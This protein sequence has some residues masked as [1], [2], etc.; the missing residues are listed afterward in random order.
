MIPDEGDMAFFRKKV[1]SGAAVEKQEDAEEEDEEEMKAEEDEDIEVKDNEEEDDD[2]ITHPYEEADPFNRPPPSPETAE[3]EFMNATV[4]QSTFQPLPPIRVESS[5]FKRL[6]KN[7][8]RM[9][10]FDDGLTA[11]D[12][13]LREQRQEMKKLMAELNEWFQQ[14]Q[15][16]YLRA[17]N[18]ILR[19]RLRGTEVKAKYKHKEAEYYENHFARVLAYYDD[20][21]GYE[22]NVVR[23]DAASDRGGEGFNTTT[24]VKDVGEEKGDKVRA[25]GPVARE[26]T[27]TRFMKWGPTQFHDTEGV[28][29][30]CRWFEGIQ[31]TFGIRLEVANEKPWAEVKKMMID[32]FFPIEEFQSTNS[33]LRDC[34]VNLLNQLFEVELMPIELGTF[35]VIIGMDWLVKHDALIVCGKKEVHIPVKAHVTEKEPKE[36]CLEDV[37]IIRDFLEV[38]PDDLLG[39]PPPRQVEFRIELMPGAAPVAR[40]P[41]HLASSEIK[42]FSDQ[43]K[44]LIY[45]QVII[46]SAFENRIYQSQPFEPGMVILSSSNYDCEIRYH[47]GKANVVA[48]ALSRKEREKPIRVR[49][50]VMTVYPDLSERILKAQIEAMKKENVKS[51]NLGR[52]L[53]P[54]FEIRSDGIRYFDRRVWLPMYGGIRD[55]IIHESH[56]LKY[57]IH[58]SSDKIYQDLKKLYWW[59]NIKADIATNVS[60]CLTRAKVKAEHQKP[61]GFWRSHQ[62][63]LGTDVNMSTAYHPEINGQSERIIQTLEDML[64]ACVIDFRKSWDRHL[65][66]VDFSYNNSYHASINAAPFEALYGRKCRKRGKLSPRYVGQFKVIDRIGPVTYKLELLDKL[67][68]IHNTFHVLNLKRCLADENLIIPLEEIQLDDKLHFI[69]EP[70]DIMDR[71]VKQLKQSRIPIVKVRW[72]SRRGP[73]YT[74]ERE[75]IFKNKYPHL[76]SNR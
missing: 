35:D 34:T 40:A 53:K 36:K 60:K 56:K 62:K 48:D 70:V 15:E 12:S 31:S 44:E 51:E 59:P 52:L 49:A 33:V 64:R 16:R 37:P 41:Y 42:E 66:L 23:A 72:N 58:P 26:C 29:G 65:P 28:V 25:G 14:I 3:Q 74:W 30:L 57:S 1:K 43:L 76:F 11:L 63:A 27:L 54:I 73:E 4:G 5:S 69:E 10:S 13:A 47:P 75:E 32:E 19:I 55:L 45:E 22:D 7:D 17:E 6:E 46:N 38:F 61:S 39:L 21:R 68:G 71:E 67:C 20:L 50:L 8:M 18:E 24:V 9:D 2:E